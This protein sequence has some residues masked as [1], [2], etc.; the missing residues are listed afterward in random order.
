MD[1]T[2]ATLNALKKDPK[3]AQL[4]SDPG[5]LKA[6]LTAPETQQLINLLNQN[7]GG[8]LKAAAQAAAGGKPE[9]LMGLLNHVTQSK[10]GAAAMEKLQKKA[11]QK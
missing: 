10:E 4:L 6:L 1:E 11:G 2:Q 3:A 5:G 8:G 9:A 7:A